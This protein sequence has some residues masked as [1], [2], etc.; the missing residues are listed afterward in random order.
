MSDRTPG[1]VRTEARDGNDAAAAGAPG[2]QE[3]VSPSVG[4]TP[5]IPTTGSMRA[6][7]DG[8]P[9]GPA[10]MPPGSIP[11]GPLSRA[12]G[13][14]GAT[15]TAAPAGTVPPP[16]AVPQA[17]PP[18]PVGAQPGAGSARPA[19]RPARGRGTKSGRGPR[20]AKLQLRHV[21]IWSAFKIS[22][23][24]SIAL[25]FIWLVAI[26]ILYLVLNGLGVFST[27]NDLFGQLG[28][29][30]GSNSSAGSVVSPGLVFGGAAVIGAINVILMTA[31]CTVATFIYNMCADLVG[32]LEVTLSE[33]D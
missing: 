29:A 24:L 27:L 25:F 1:S 3:A 4:S 7:G 13:A 14:G 21:D 22:L 12:A 9:A 11:Q 30:S 33:R 17:A 28:S 16:P 10:T 5:A 23:V 2:P 15:A 32:G 20:R 19:D 18:G 26:G 8:A 31:L 6:Q